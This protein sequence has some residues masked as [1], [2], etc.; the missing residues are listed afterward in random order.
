VI[1][2]GAVLGNVL[3]INLPAAEGPFFVPKVL[4]LL[5]HEL[6]KCLCGL[7]LDMRHGRG[8]VQ[9]AGARFANAGRSTG[10]CSHKLFINFQHEGLLL[11]EC[12]VGH[13]LEGSIGGGADVTFKPTDVLSFN[14][15]VGPSFIGEVKDLVEVII[16]LFDTGFLHDGS[17]HETIQG[18]V[19]FMGIGP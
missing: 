7:Y 10:L 2:L 9:G 19:C 8:W 12:N 14:C 6:G 4:S 13:L 18:L 17:T 16:V 15:N 11:G 1:E 5:V 3:D